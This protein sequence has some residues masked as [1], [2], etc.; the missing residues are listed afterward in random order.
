VYIRALTGICGIQLASR[1][2]SANDVLIKGESTLS[3]RLYAS[4][5]LPTWQCYLFVLAALIHA[6]TAS[7]VAFRSPAE[8]HHPTFTAVASF[9]NVPL[10]YFSLVALAQ[11]V[12]QRV[13]PL[14][15]GST[16]RGATVAAA[17][18][19][20]TR[21]SLLRPVY[22]VLLLTVCGTAVTTW[23]AVDLYRLHSA[24]AL[25]P[26]PASSPFALPS[27]L[28]APDATLV[29]SY[30][31]LLMRYVGLTP[32][33]R[34]LHDVA[35]SSSYARANYP[36]GGLAALVSRAGDTDGATANG[37][38]D[39]GGGARARRARHAYRKALH[40]SRASATLPALLGW[41]PVSA[42]DAALEGDA[43]AATGVSVG[44]GAGAEANAEAAGSDSASAGSERAVAR[45]GGLPSVPA[46]LL[47]LNIPAVAAVAVAAPL[48][49]DVFAALLGLLAAR[50]R[51]VWRALSYDRLCPI[52][53]VQPRARDIDICL[54]HV[55]R[56]FT[57][58]TMLAFVTIAVQFIF[59]TLA[60]ITDKPHAATA[61]GTP[62][63]LFSLIAH[64]A[65]LSGL[66]LFNLA[67]LTA[68]IEYLNKVV[69]R[70]YVQ[71]RLY[72]TVRQR[73]ALVLLAARANAAKRDA[74]AANDADDAD[75][76]DNAN[77]DVG[78]TKAS[79]VG[80]ISAAADEAAELESLRARGS[81]KR[82]KKK[83]AKLPW[84]VAHVASANAALSAKAQVKSGAEPSAAS[85]AG[86]STPGGSTYSAAFEG[87]IPTTVRAYEA[88]WM[89][90]LPNNE[91]ASA[92]VSGARASWHD[93]SRAHE[94]A[95]LGQLVDSTELLVAFHF[96]GWEVH[97]S[98]AFGY[99]AAGAAGLASLLKDKARELI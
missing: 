97:Y 89:L 52:T 12:E 35:H 69:H 78:A 73:V 26:A 9:L 41:Q 15:L 30:S 1:L 53:T 21:R 16:L 40:V 33:G 47:L 6:V 14:L 32:D 98:T 81:A 44:A 76:G 77:A 67:E 90:P 83:A 7:L 43:N 23:H 55:E 31:A 74:D 85:D 93:G 36:Y 79:G 66:V 61:Q 63:L 11:I 87:K 39:G 25:P 57:G 17:T 84:L 54:T 88:H 94:E 71:A 5:A 13:I 50:T 86:S 96:M 60:Y 29:S 58:P 22:A 59:G 99:L 38:S 45:L 91:D 82:L 8:F 65:A 27:L 19:T 2:V 64:P 18:I 68:Q 24:L 48:G 70:Y 92:V 28:S 4:L 75:A 3:R 72:S 10:V 95:L 42:A 80:S 49:F 46:W 37:S 62:L 20:E 51:S 56:S 34:R